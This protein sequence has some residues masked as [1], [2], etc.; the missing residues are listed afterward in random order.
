MA[1]YESSF[2]AS[3]SVITVTPA[4]SDLCDRI[5]S[6]AWQTKVK[7]TVQYVSPRS[8]L[9]G[10][11]FIIVLPGEGHSTGCN[12]IIRLFLYSYFFAISVRSPL[13]LTASGNPG[14]VLWIRTCG[15]GTNYPGGLTLVGDPWPCPRLEGPLGSREVHLRHKEGPLGPRESPLSPREG[16]LRLYKR[17]L[18]DLETALS[19]LERPAQT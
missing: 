19:D 5:I 15:L 11:V 6:R 10:Q 2:V 13:F 18:S 8:G 4:G 9:V 1:S 12:E 14:K 16:P 3:M 7:L 17:A